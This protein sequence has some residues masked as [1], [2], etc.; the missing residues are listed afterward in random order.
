MDTTAT[1]TPTA[2]SQAEP[3]FRFANYYLASGS[4]VNAIFRETF[5][6]QRGMIGDSIFI[7]VVLFGLLFFFFFRFT[8]LVIQQ[9]GLFG[10]SFSLLVPPSH[11]IK[12]VV[13]F[14]F[15]FLLFCVIRLI[16]LRAGSHECTD[17]C[18]ELFPISPT[19][20]SSSFLQLSRK[21]RR[22]EIE[23]RVVYPPPL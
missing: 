11:I 12:I 9:R 23:N 10:L 1:T 6:R 13:L 20:S 21:F 18:P 2:N 17:F 14:G 19:T 16:G 4:R 5:E 3:R 22:N 7:P 15:G 8:C